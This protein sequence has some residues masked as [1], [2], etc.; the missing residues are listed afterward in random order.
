MLR[1]VDEKGDPIPKFEVKTWMFGGRS[2]S[3]WQNGSDGGIP[4]S[5]V[6]A[7]A[8]KAQ[9]VV[10]TVRADGYASMLRSLDGAELEKL[11]AGTTSLV[12]RRG[13]DVEISFRL[14]EGMTWPKDLK[15]E[16]YFFA[17][18]DTVR[19]LGKNPHRD[20]AASP[21]ANMLNAHFDH[22]GVATLRLSSDGAPICVAIPCA[23]LFAILRVRAVQ[24]AQSQERATRNPDR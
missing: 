22:P 12:L 7:P 8:G 1:V 15:P 3:A 17:L 2:D 10:L 23:R 5:Q 24:H 20:H 14:P 4:V 9:A 18:E 19:A 21:D 6:L 16:L 13:K 11:K